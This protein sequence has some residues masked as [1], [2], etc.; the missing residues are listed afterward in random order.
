[1]PKAL[2]VGLDDCTQDFVTRMQ[3]YRSITGMASTRSR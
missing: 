3:N 2:I 1:M